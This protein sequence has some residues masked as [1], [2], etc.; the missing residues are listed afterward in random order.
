M[1]KLPE[2]H[3]ASVGA[4]KAAGGGMSL[5]EGPQAVHSRHRVLEIFSRVG[6]GT[7]LHIHEAGPGLDSGDRSMRAF[8]MLSLCPFHDLVP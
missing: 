5:R 8:C 4:D 3:P 1:S 2:G 6:P 7:Y